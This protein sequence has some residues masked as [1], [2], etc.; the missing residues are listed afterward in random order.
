[1]PDDD[2]RKNPPTGDPPD[3][4]DDG[5]DGDAGGDSTDWAAEARKWRKQARENKRDADRLG[6][7]ARKFDELE[8]KNKTETE[9]LSDA[10][11]KAEERATAAERELARARIALR[12]GLTEAQAKRLVGDTEEE[13][14]A[15]ADEYLKDLKPAGDDDGDESPPSRRP[16]ERL[17]PGTRSRAEPEETD[18]AKL[19][20][21]I[22]ERAG[23]RI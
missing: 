11:R 21:R 18:P 22:K 14:E 16:T 6:E 17:R 8:E 3:D 7:K 20:A 19:A 2:D 9:K 10:H 4:G 12:K 15:D 1:M 13:L 23:G 5:D